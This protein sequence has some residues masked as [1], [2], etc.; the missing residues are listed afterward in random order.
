MTGI[1]AE[2]STDEVVQAYR[3]FGLRRMPQMVL[4]NA[5]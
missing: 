4:V 3:A 1:K 2:L 5:A